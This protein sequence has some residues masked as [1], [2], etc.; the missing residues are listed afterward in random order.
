[1]RK[2]L[3]CKIL[4]L[5][6][7]QKPLIIFER[8]KNHKNTFVGITL[9][10]ELYCCFFKPA[11]VQAPRQSFSNIWFPFRKVNPYKRKTRSP[12]VKNLCLR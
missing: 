8:N 2:W 10:S 12:S 11:C 3:T 6:F 4:C 7:R 5:E 9:L 1:M